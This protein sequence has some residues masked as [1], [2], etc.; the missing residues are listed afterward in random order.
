SRYSEWRDRYSWQVIDFPSIVASDPGRDALRPRPVPLYVL[1][2]ER[3]PIRALSTER[4]PPGFPGLIP[5]GCGKRGCPGRSR[6][7][8]DGGLRL[9]WHGGHRGRRSPSDVT[10][11]KGTS[12]ATCAHGLAARARPPQSHGLP[13][14]GPRT[15]L[16]T[17]GDGMDRIAARR[18]MRAE[19][20][21]RL[22]E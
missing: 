2:T 19:F 9:A 7:P 22:Y 11:H 21:R 15:D 8:A 12:R 6:R 1:Q 10:H 20:L 4:K 17:D 5:A 18:A 14:A 16:A 3:F 13:A